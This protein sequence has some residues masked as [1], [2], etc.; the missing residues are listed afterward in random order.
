MN[1]IKTMQKPSGITLE[2]YSEKSFVLRGDTRPY[3]EYIKKL[4]GKW[5]PKLQD[6]AGWLFP[7]T[8]QDTVSK[9]IDTGEIDD[10]DIKYQSEK[11]RNGTLEEHINYLTLKVTSIEKSINIIL[12]KIENMEK[13]KHDDAKVVDE[14]DE[15][16]ESEQ[17]IVPVRLLGKK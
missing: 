8:K 2:P 4:G 14:S 10:D 7:K 3:K 9:W 15:S 16:D 5:A 13:V 12:A 11:S 6:G 1:S 17:E